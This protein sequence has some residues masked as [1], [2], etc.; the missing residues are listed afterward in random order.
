[1]K[2]RQLIDGASFGP[3][4]L[5]VIGQ[6]FDDAWAQLAPRYSDDTTVVEAAR[7]RLAE[8]V[9]RLAETNTSVSTLTEAAL[10]AM[11]KRG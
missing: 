8:T 4:S 7:L 6:A 9:L 1:M 10:V 2:A 5:K 11:D 3:E